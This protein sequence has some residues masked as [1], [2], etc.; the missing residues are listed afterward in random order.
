MT[1]KKWSSRRSIRKFLKCRICLCIPL[2]L[3]FISFIISLGIEPSDPT[4]CG[5]VKPYLIHKSEKEIWCPTIAVCTFGDP[6]SG[7][8]LITAMWCEGNSREE[9][10]IYYSCGKTVTAMG[11]KNIFDGG[12]KENPLPYIWT[13]GNPDHFHYVALLVEGRLSYKKAVRCLTILDEYPVNDEN[14][15]NIQMSTV[16]EDI[17]NELKT[18]LLISYIQKD[19]F[20]T[21]LNYIKI[22]PLS[23]EKI[24]NECFFKTT[25]NFFAHIYLKRFYSNFFS[26]EKHPKYFLF[27]KKTSPEI[28]VKMGD[29]P[30]LEKKSKTIIISSNSS[31]DYFEHF[32]ILPGRI[33]GDLFL[34]IYTNETDIKLGKFK[35]EPNKE[36]QYEERVRVKDIYQFKK[37]EVGGIVYTNSRVHFF[38]DESG[39]YIIWTVE[40]EESSED[41]LKKYYYYLYVTK[42]EME[43]SALVKHILYFLASSSSIIVIL[44]I[45]LNYKKKRGSKISIF[46]YLTVVAIICSIL[47]FLWA[48]T[49]HKGNLFQ[50][51]A[52]CGILATA[53]LILKKIVE[54]ITI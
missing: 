19:E 7:E 47:I 54:W 23:G 8:K 5:P 48:A 13:S 24:K 27:Y 33:C 17:D 6:L 29:D 22:N 39:L 45:A 36:Y 3:L 32:Y 15:F 30:N 21:F 18:R 44:R 14:I 12:S 40:N 42:I 50:W 11:D 53:G 37:D 41:N 25:E 38:E 16:Q 10:N 28:Y 26:S 31:D 43:R 52:I 9:K 4:F 20:Q 2:A 1:I 34:I 46:W 51:S 49:Y 35:I